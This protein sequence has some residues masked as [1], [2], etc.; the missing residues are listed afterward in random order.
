MKIFIIAEAGVNHNGSI[1]LAR[2]LIDAGAAA[3]ADAV[4]FQTFKAEKIISR[5]A[6]KAQY[7][8][9][10]TDARETQRDMVNQLELD[11]AAHQQ[12]AD[13]CREKA[14][15]FMSTPFDLES[16]D[17]LVEL[18]VVRI[19]IASGEITNAPLL[20]KI[21]RTG[22]PVIMSTGMAT[23]GEV[24]TALGVLAFGYLGLAP[25]P[26]L[27]GFREAF[28][29]PEGQEALKS[30]VALLHC[31]TEYPA[32]FAEVNLRAMDTMA[33]AFALPVGYSDHTP[34]IAVA[35][36][37]AA[38]GAMI[39]EKHFTLDQGLPGPDHKASLEPWEL[40][41]LVQNLRQ[42]EVALGSPL[43]VSSP[44]ELKNRDIVR[45]SLVAAR[46]IRKGERFSEDNLTSKRPGNGTSPLCYWDWLGRPAEKDYQPDEI[47]SWQDD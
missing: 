25:R 2:Q 37:A 15:E 45:K 5:S 14:I 13:Y 27:P 41:S 30:K 43:K 28:G 33:A 46:S 6:P 4:K 34:G 9:Q 1:D 40:Q 38:R 47:I 11:Q 32:P 3:G 20:L 22:L 7:Q 44:S 23:L 17:L 29:M 21:A 26:S 39:I 24:E 10:S 12:L 18:G 36:A 35:L 19:K 8:L 31:T 16:I 42:V